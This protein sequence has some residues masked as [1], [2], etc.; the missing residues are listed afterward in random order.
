MTTRIRGEPQPQRA[1]PHSQPR[2]IRNQQQAR[3]G[4]FGSSPK[5]LLKQMMEESKSSKIV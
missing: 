5:H 3:Q 2:P 4:M 1:Q